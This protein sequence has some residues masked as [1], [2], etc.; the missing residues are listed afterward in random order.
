MS[1]ISIVVPIYN[2]K[3]YMDNCIISIMK[4]TYRDFELILVDDGSNDGSSLICDSYAKKDKRIKVI[5]KD[6]GGLSDARN[7][8]TAIANGKYITYVD[9]DDYINP[10]YLEALLQGIVETGADFSITGIKKVYSQNEIKEIKINNVS[11]QK[12]SSHNAL[13]SV[14]YQKEYDV[15][16]SGILLPVDLAKKYTFPKGRLF[17]DL[18][19]TYKY[20]FDV[21]TVAIVGA[22]LYYYL[23]RSNSIMDGNVNI[24]YVIDML[25]ASDNIVDACEAFPDLRNAAENKKF[26]N[27]CSLARKGLK[28]IPYKEKNKI[29]QFL[30]SVKFLIIRDSNAR[31]KNR[32]AA[33]ALCGGDFVLRWLYY[34]EKFIKKRI[35]L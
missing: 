29:V 22:K 31:L 9:S 6:N 26:S 18:F 5:H 8:G 32:L 3:K 13:L 24:K 16:A 27:Y 34:I 1:T 35:N 23:Q 21:N 12:K 11:I 10:I 28:D 20:Y 14:L 2:V 17:E 30:N 25:D 7:V 4:Q 19:T 33:V 15:S